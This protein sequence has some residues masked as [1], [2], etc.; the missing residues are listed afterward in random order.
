MHVVTNSVLKITKNFNLELQICHSALIYC[1][2]VFSAV[3]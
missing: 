3:Q 1:I 2:S